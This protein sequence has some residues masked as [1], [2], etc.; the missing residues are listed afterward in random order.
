MQ[1]RRFLALSGLGTLGAMV[2]GCAEART[3]PIDAGAID[4]AAPPER[5]AGPTTSDAVTIAAGFTVMLNDPS[6]SGHDHEC[7]VAAGTY[8]SAML[9]MFLG[10]SHLVVFSVDDLARLDRGEQIPFATSGP[11]PG[12]GHCGLAWKDGLYEPSRTRVDA[13]TTHAP[14]GTPMAVCE[15]R[16]T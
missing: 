15:A 10:G 3:L 2:G 4:D 9:P 6:C 8:T 12:H 14:A 16:H 7:E 5:D 11:G 1:R 13:C